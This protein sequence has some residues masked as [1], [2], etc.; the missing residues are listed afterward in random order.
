MFYTRTVKKRTVFPLE[1]AEQSQVVEYLELL[2]LQGKITLFSAVPNNTF[3]NSWN[4][5][6]K[7]VKEGVRQGVPDLLILTPSTILFLEMKRVKG[8]VV[9]EDQKAWI[10]A[11]QDRPGVV[12]K[13]AHGF[14]EARNIIES[15]LT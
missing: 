6:R 7:Q 9:S 13:V 15:C 2:K 14:I 12:A 3:T 4:Q 10:L 5:K 1:I 8:G 11:L